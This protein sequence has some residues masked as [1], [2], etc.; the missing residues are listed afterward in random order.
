[1]LEDIEKEIYKIEK[2]VLKNQKAEEKESSAVLQ[3]EAFKFSPKW[4]R[5]IL[6]LISLLVFITIV[7]ALYFFIQFNKGNRD[8]GLEI[9]SVDDVY[10]G[11]VFEIATNIN[12]QTDVILNDVVL[13]INL[14]SG[15]LNVS[16][17]GDDKNLIT[18]SIGD[19][20]GGGL[21][22]K[23]F[24]F[25]AT[26][27]KGSGQNIVV[28]ISYLN[29]GTR[30]EEQE[31][32]KISIKDPAI[33]LG[34]KVP[35]QLLSGSVFN[36]KVSYKNKSNFDFPDAVL[37]AK[38]PNSFRF[39][40]SDLE[41]DGLN[42]RWRL[43]EIKAGSEG[44][45]E[46]KGVL[47]GTDNLKF[48][49]PFSINNVILGEDYQIDEKIAEVTISP[50]PISLKVI[51]N[52]QAD[53]VARIGDR[54]I[55]TIQYQNNSGIALT[56][57]QIKASFIG[58]I[59]DFSTLQTNAK[60][61]FQMQ[62][63]IWNSSN[64][65]EFRVLDP[66]TKGEVTAEIKLKPQFTILRL[67]DKNFSVRFNAEMSSPSV[68]YYLEASQTK[69]L[70]SLETKIAGLTTID[71]QIFYR[72]ANSGIA[73]SGSIPPKVNQSTEYTVHWIVK[74]YSTDIKN[75][76]IRTIL[77]PGVEWAGIVKSNIDSAPLYNEE[78]HE[79]VWD[80]GEVIA[81]KG[82]ISKPIEAVFQI[83]ATPD[84]SNVGQYQP[85]IKETILNAID[86]F[87]GLEILSS[88]TALTTLLSD[89]STVGQGGGKVV[90]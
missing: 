36:L 89:D 72:D 15:L 42:N 65:S 10:R 67:N 71:A 18:E 28:K 56:D 68:P 90:P 22:K 52:R 55:Y 59:L 51:L 78:N 69:A 21:S 84:A 62:T 64:V 27:E 48:E 16:T 8:I 7:S 9:S 47:E 17:I 49:I 13:S 31:T 45:F 29:N 82:V 60:I 40:S 30:F 74:N 39:I 35:D 58:D 37:E 57:V 25:L 61:N 86:E 5:R 41:P 20:G 73:N 75:T 44:E 14:P 77:E 79:V 11:S 76:R 83:K 12:N 6:W 26:G 33:E 53:Y 66:G 63:L 50:S 2:E 38:Y 87:T 32:K 54:L 70:A 24:R 3:K 88:D 85:L 4:F 1:M 43:G 46:I 80:I 81:T 23:T 34:I 19:I